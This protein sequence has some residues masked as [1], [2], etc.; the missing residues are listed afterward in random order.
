MG[1]SGKNIVMSVESVPRVSKEEESHLTELE[2]DQG[3]VVEIREVRE[4]C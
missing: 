4:L 3:R 1:N 2:S